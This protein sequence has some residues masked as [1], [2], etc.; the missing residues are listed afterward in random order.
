[1]INF[2]IIF[3]NDLCRKKKVERGTYMEVEF[4]G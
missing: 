3:G 2:G 1:M 4:I